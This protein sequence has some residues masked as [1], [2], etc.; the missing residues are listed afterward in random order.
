[1][2]ER[3]PNHKHCRHCGKAFIGE[4]NYCSEECKG[5]STNTL[6]KKKR[7][8]MALYV[9]TFVVLILALWAA[10]AK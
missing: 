3:I 4:D 8:L 10:T 7:Q 9:I 2:T 5:T 6:Q 1:M